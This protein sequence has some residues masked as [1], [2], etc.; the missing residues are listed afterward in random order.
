MYTLLRREILQDP[1][2]V[3][4]YIMFNNHLSSS[5]KPRGVIHHKKLLQQILDFF[6]V[7]S[8]LNNSIESTIFTSVF[9][10]TN[11]VDVYSGLT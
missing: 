1:G 11:T 10:I 2:T 3:R 9:F 7:H 6:F 8:I 4:A 5:I